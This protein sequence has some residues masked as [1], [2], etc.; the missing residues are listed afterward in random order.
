MYDK[1]LVLEILEQ[2][3]NAIEVVLSRFEVVEDSDFFLESSAGMEKLDAQEIFYVC[4]NNLPQLQIAVK[5][6]IRDLQ[7]KKIEK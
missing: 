2:I 7:Q 4:D 1:S 3:A 5:T 6:I